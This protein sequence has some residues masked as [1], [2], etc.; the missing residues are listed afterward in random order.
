VTAAAAMEE[1]ATVR[2]H[3]WHDVLEIRHRGCSATEHGRIERAPSRGEER[4]GGETA[5]DLEPPVRDVL[6]RHAVAGEV[7]RHP[8]EQRE[9]P[10][11][12][13]RACSGAGGDV[14]RDDHEL[15]LMEPEG[16][17]CRRPR[18]RMLPPMAMTN[19]FRRFF[20]SP[21]EGDDEDAARHE[22]YGG[23]G[24]A[25]A[26]VAQM[27]NISGG[28]VIPGLAGSEGASSVEGELSEYERPSDLAP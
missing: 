25:D 1:L 15:D 28:S 9:G 4:K 14:E 16:V 18:R 2:P 24:V 12:D 10:R 17:W 26:D 20:G 22:E 21:P 19:W 13:E 5:A 27:E 23:E 11:P 6:M 3:P 7:E 8:E